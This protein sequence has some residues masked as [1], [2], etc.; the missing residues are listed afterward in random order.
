MKVVILTYGSR[1]DIEPFIPLSLGLMA[2]GHSVKLAAPARFKLLIEQRGITFVSL[3]GDPAELSQRLN[4]SGHNFFRIIRSLM[5]HAIEIGADV[6]QQTEKACSDA[7]IILHTFLH[8]VG[9]HTLA[10]EKNIPDVHIQLFPMFTPTGDYPNVTLP[11]LKLRSANR[12]THQISRLMT[13]WGA[14]IGFEQVRRRSGFQKRK[15]YSPFDDNSNRPPT[16][17]LCAWS[18]RVLPPS[19]DWPWNV[20]VTG[21]LFEN[22]DSTY[23]PPIELQRFL[24]AGEP[25]ICISFGSMINRD[26]RKIDHILHEAL[27]QTNNR[28]IILSGWS[29]VRNQS[30][31][32]IL[33]LDA[34]PHQWLLPRCKMV[35][36][37]GGAGT[38]SAGLRAGIANI[39]VPFTAD[40]P[41]W[42]YRVHAIGG[43]P[44]PIPVK[45]LSVENLTQAIFDA[46]APLLRMHSQEIGHQLRSEDGVRQAIGRIEKYSNEF[47]RH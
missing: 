14:K 20:Q 41:F 11:D 19:K 9:G 8:A 4:D 34:I 35:I 40:Q 1:G 42:G 29:E 15:L 38:T 13:V 21:Y 37:H 23:Q 22:F 28:G 46:D 27:R 5:H 31:D 12:L 24:D 30:S 3:A 45:K 39:V 32:N 2:R 7:D 25:P 36:H 18:P 16:P 47:I 17:I 6:L 26:A 43:G 10:R 44:K 33:Y